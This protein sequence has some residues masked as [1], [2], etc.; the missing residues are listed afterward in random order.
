MCMYACVYQSSVLF[1]LQQVFS[2][3][4]HPHLF[5]DLLVQTGSLILQFASSGLRKRVT[6]LREKQEKKQVSTRYYLNKMFLKKLPMHQEK[7]PY[8][9]KG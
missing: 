4:P 5:D 2:S 1:L 9:K 8:C 7:W 3:S 6:T